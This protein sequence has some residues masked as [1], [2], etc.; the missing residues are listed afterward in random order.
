MRELWRH[1]PLNTDAERRLRHQDQIDSSEVGILERRANLVFA[2][3]VTKRLDVVCRLN[4]IFLRRQAPGQLLSE[5]GDIDN[6]LKT[7]LDALSVP[8]AAQER[9][10]FDVPALGE[11]LY[12]LLQDDSLVTGLSVDTARLLKP[13]SDERDLVA[14]IHVKVAATRLTYA[15]MDMAS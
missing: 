3:L 6:R 11:P 1:H 13:T 8:P 2:P 4:I 10:S 15:N 9:E 5:G 12:C 14:L 7:L